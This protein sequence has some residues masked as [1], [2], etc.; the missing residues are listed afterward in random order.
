MNTAM[1]TN[2]GVLLLLALAS[3]LLSS[4]EIVLGIRGTAGGES[5]HRAWAIVFGGLVAIWARADALARRTGQ[6]F[7]FGFY[8]MFLWPVVLPYH[9]VR[10][11][12]IKGF[13]GFLGLG[14]LYLAPFLLGFVAFAYLS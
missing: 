12:G 13:I 14:A 3:L 4:Y 7:D 8:V 5:L 10:T 9:M 2:F 11:R 1:K 6:P